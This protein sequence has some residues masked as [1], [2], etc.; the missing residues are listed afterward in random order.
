VWTIRDMRA[1]EEPYIPSWVVPSTAAGTI[2][3]LKRGLE[4]QKAIASPRGH[5]RQAYRRVRDELLD[6][7]MPSAESRISAE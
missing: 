1:E 4:E 5:A 3:T 6:I 2:S 7:A